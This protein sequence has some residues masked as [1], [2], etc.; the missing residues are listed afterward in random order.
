MGNRLAYFHI[1]TRYGIQ[2]GP[3]FVHDF[4]LGT[5][6]QFERRFDF[7][8]IDTESMLVEFCAAGLAGYGLDFRHSHQQ[9][10]RVP[11]DIVR[12]LQRHARESADVDGERAFVERREEAA[13]EAEEHAKS[14][15]KQSQDA[16]QCDFF[17]P[18]HPFQRHAVPLLKPSHQRRVLAGLVAAFAAEKEAAEHR[19]Q[20]QC[21]QCG[22]EKCC[23]KGNSERSEHTAFHSCQEEK[24]NEADHDDEGRVE[25]RKTHLT[26]SI[27][28]HL[29]NGLALR[30]RKF[31]VLAQMLEHIFHVNDGVIHQRAD[32]NRHTSDTHRIDSQ[33]HKLQCQYR[34]EQ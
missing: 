4:P 34:H 7:R 3:D 12:L 6:A 33:S 21:D 28:N 11:A 25:N 30:L 26:G 2:L 23:D 18:E 14:D 32:G 17:M 24:R 13:S 9:C 15:D 22:G 5:L 20:C 29:D 1:D 27:E 19:G 31:P 8:N 10:L 16:S